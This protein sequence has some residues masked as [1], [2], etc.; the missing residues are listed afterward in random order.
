MGPGIL[1]GRGVEYGADFIL[2]SPVRINGNSPSRGADV[3]LGGRV[4]EYCW[5]RSAVG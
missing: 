2:A 4:K 5:N 3:E 1:D